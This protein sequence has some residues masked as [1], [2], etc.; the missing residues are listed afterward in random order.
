MAARNVDLK[1]ALREA[2]EWLGEPSS[3]PTKKSASKTKS[4]PAFPTLDDAVR[5][6]ERKLK[7]RKTRCDEYHDADG[8][9]HFV[10]GRLDGEPRSDG[11]KNK[12]YRP[13]YRSESG[14]VIADPTGKLPLFHLRKLLVPPLSSTNPL[15]EFVFVVEG[16]KCVCE[17]E[18]LGLV[19]TTSAH[20][21]ESPHKTDWSPLAGRKV[22]IL[23]DNDDEGRRY[24]QTVAAI[25]LALSPEAKVWL[26][27]LPGLPPKGDCVDWID[28]HDDARTPED[29][30]GELLALVE[31][32]EV[33]REVRTADITT[34][35]AQARAPLT[36]RTID[37]ILC[38]TFDP[39]DLILPNGYLTAGDL[40]AIC[41]I[42]GIGKSRLTMQFAMC[43]RAGRD[44]LGWPTN[45]R[46]LRFLFL[47][48]ENSCRRLQSD[49][50]RMLSA[51]K[52]DEQTHIKEG[53]FFHTLEG[54]DD[55]FLA[56]D[57][58]NRKRIEQAI[59]ETGADVIICDPLRDFSLD[60]LNSD[61]VMGDT[62]RD[63]LRVTKRGNPKRVPLTV[64]H[65][66]TGKAGVQKVTGW[67]RASFGR[68]SKVLLMMSRAV[69]NIGQARPDDNAV[70]II[71]SGKCNNAQEFK[72]FAAQ[73]DFDTLLYARDDD[74][75]IQNWQNEITRKGTGTGRTTPTKGTI[76]DMFNLIP[77]TGSISQTLLLATATDESMGTKRLAE[78][79]AR[80][81]LAILIENGRAFP[82]YIAR[83]KT[84]PLIEISRHPQTE[85][86]PVQSGL[87]I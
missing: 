15:D 32:G 56:L 65:A 24:A 21:A 1:T 29:I 31:K 5:F 34:E 41:G 49:L 51:F 84:R 2:A 59:I 48:T 3:R 78:K 61:K 68:N 55:G 47:Q 13:F 43:C 36:I 25:L 6:M 20:G 18:T 12:E 73:I 80:Q 76:E 10:V 44:F 52:P 70:I 79:K 40:T 82:W 7:M 72:P 71:A 85:K 11:K 27:E 54:D 9:V 17:L 81:F 58:E 53:I 45:G 83:P 66:V 39:A 42:G 37:E 38:M 74:F 64:H 67:E 77:P 75:D 16:E 22:I 63:I 50:Q 87:T 33:I 23:P 14:W 4:K 57:A 19:A 86:T 69:I 62:L 30:T 8:N 28:A 35:T 26:I 46:D 60:D